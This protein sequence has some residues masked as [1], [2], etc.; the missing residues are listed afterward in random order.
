[1]VWRSF[2]GS[3]SLALANREKSIQ[4]RARMQPRDSRQ[5]LVLNAD[6]G[7][8]VPCGL[9]LVEIRYGR[10]EIRLLNPLIAKL[11]I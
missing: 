2:E 3:A 9:V 10:L 4:S 11:G 1:M 8:T 6:F 5:S 7:A